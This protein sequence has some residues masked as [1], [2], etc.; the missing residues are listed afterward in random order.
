MAKKMIIAA[1]MTDGWLPTTLEGGG[2][3]FQEGEQLLELP[4]DWYPIFERLGFTMLQVDPPHLDTN[5]ISEGCW[6]W[7]RTDELI[8]KCLTNGFRPAYFPHW[9]WPPV[10]YEKSD[11]FTGCRCLQ[12]NECIPCFS[13]WSPKIKSWFQRCIR[14]LRDHYSSDEQLQAIYLGVHGDFG[15]A[16]Y[17]MGMEIGAER[18][19]YE[20]GMENAHWHFDFWCNDEYAQKD[21]RDFLLKKY[22]TLSNLNSAWASKY[23]SPDKIKYPSKP[24]P[25]NRRLW[26]DF[27]QWYYDSMTNFTALVAEI[28]RKYFPQTLLMLPM[29][30]GVEPLQYGQDNTGL[31]KAMKKYD[32]H[33]RSTA[34]SSTQFRKDLSVPERFQ[35]NY[36]ILKRIASA[37]KF[38]GLSFWIEP[39][40]PPGMSSIAAVTMIFEALCCGAVGYYDWSRSVYKNRDIYE[41]YKDYLKVEEPQVDVAVFFPTTHHHFHVGSQLPKYFW[42]GCSDIRRVIDYDVLDERLITDGALG[43]YRVLIIFEGGVIEA[44][45]LRAISKWVENGGVLLCCNIGQVS[46]VEGDFSCYRQLFGF[47]PSSKE[48]V[49]SDAAGEKIVIKNKKFL[50]HLDRHPNLSTKRYYLNLAEDVEILASTAEGASIWAKKTGKGATVFFAG[51][52]EEREMYYELIR[53]AVYNLSG[54]DRS[55]KDAFSFNDR[56]DNV[57]AT[58][59]ED[60]IIFLNLEEHIVEK[61]AN[62]KTVKLEPFSI[63]LIV[64]C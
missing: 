42:Q 38:Y 16:M 22:G 24:K 48:V 13:I 44:S 23:D 19:R 33:I 41:R 62:G 56:W 6:D 59:F 10:W 51:D 36:P 8:E 53:D 21:F 9:H 52:W 25:N 29:G 35:R 28:Y 1:T 20:R 54:L 32:V 43:K 26:L 2:H 63:R 11:D 4:E 47:T 60:K 40:Y 46:T 14:A 27:I 18:L 12:H 61:K 49:D 37:C 58:L 55:F 57:F 34:G 17:P 5:E 39:P 15:E 3:I 30:G 64:V 45:C 50:R 31:P 7:S